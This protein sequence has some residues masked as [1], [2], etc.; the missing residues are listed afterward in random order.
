MKK[1]YEAPRAEREVF[2]GDVITLSF[3][4]GDPE[5]VISYTHL[6]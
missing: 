1:I 2:V 6:Q 4:G 3:G 5:L